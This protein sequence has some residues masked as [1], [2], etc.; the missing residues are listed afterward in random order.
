MIRVQKNL[1]GK[2][3]EETREAKT[4][5][6]VHSQVAQHFLDCLKDR[7]CRTCLNNRIIKLKDILFHG[8][9]QGN[10]KNS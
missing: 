2:G 10:M 6:L 8:E 7:W 4:T 3:G 5:Q 9:G 1:P